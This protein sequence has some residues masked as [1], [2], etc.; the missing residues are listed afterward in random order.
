MQAP[1]QIGTRIAY[2]GFSYQSGCQEAINNAA[3]KNVLLQKD[4][5][6]MS[7][8]TISVNKIAAPTESECKRQIET[9]INVRQIATQEENWQNGNIQS[10]DIRYE[11]INI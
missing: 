2:G 8:F 6:M 5:V 7:L 10:K 4:P 11:T 3:H 9:A 1:K